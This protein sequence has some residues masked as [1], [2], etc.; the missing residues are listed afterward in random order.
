MMWSNAGRYVPRKRAAD[1]MSV[2][3]SASNSSTTSKETLPYSED[4][5]SSDN[6]QTSEDNDS[7]NCSQHDNDS[8]HSVGLPE[9]ITPLDISRRFSNHGSTAE[10]ISSKPRE[11]K[12]PRHQPRDISGVCLLAW[13]AV[14]AV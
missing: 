9:I 8:E 14:C 1:E 2:S 13:R 10:T 4:D 6:D 12:R 3:S 7:P 5:A 11:S